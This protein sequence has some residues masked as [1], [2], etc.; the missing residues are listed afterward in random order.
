MF[1]VY[2]KKNINMKKNAMCLKKIMQVSLFSLS[3]LLKLSK[4]FL[5]IP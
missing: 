4:K 2:K 5:I 1:E 3:S